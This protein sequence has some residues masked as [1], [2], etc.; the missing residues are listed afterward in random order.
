MVPIKES[1]DILAVLYKNSPIKKSVDIL[2]ILC[3]SYRPGGLS[4]GLDV[5]MYVL[6]S[7][8]RKAVAVGR[9]GQGPRG[10]DEAHGSLRERVG[11]GEG[12]RLRYSQGKKKAHTP[13]TF[14]VFVLLFASPSGHNPLTARE[15]EKK[16]R[17]VLVCFTYV[18]GTVAP[19]QLY[20]SLLYIQVWRHTEVGCVVHTRILDGQQRGQSQIAPEEPGWP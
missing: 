5:R 11:R 8:D 16:K 6:F 10:G 2:A 14:F 9:D 12:D 19:Q 20:R 17:Q 15:G 3:M 13:S 18:W 7:Q 4:V 1:V